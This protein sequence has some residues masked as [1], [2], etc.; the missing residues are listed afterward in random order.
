VRRLVGFL[1]WTL[2]FWLA[3]CAHIGPLP[4]GRTGEEQAV[5]RVWTQ[6]YGMADAPPRIRWIRGAELSCTDPNSLKPGFPVIV[7]E[8]DEHGCACREGF[9]YR[10]DQVSVADHGEPSFADMA[11][12]HELL[13]AALWRRGVFLGHHKRPDFYPSVDLANDLLRKSHL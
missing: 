8:G 10:W 13:H 3:G 11:M 2:L 12:S 6:A 4:P 7:V 5:W 9:T 1:G